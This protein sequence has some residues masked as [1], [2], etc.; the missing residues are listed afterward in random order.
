MSMRPS[1]P[2]VG[3][4]ERTSFARG[5]AR[6]SAIWRVRPPPIV[7]DWRCTPSDED[8]WIA[9]G[10]AKLTVD[11]EAALATSKRR[12]LK[13]PL[14]T[15]ALQNIAHVLSE[16]LDSPERAIEALSEALSIRPSDTL[17]RAGRGVL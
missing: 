9:R 16:R 15:V 2:A 5:S 10:Y 8:S 17:A 14:S 13:I 12:S 1:R 11:P 6:R 4:L 3:K 7:R